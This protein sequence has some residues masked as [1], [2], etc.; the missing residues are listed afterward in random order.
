[1]LVNNLLEV[2]VVENHEV[3]RVMRQ[4]QSQNLVVGQDQ[5]RDRL[6]FVHPKLLVMN[7]RERV[8]FAIGKFY[9]PTHR[10]SSS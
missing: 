1:M 9:W 5:I 2:V 6:I 7:T 3:K 8:L 4:K 10:S